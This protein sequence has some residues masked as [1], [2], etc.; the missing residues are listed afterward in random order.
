MQVGMVLLAS[1][2]SPPSHV[3]R[4]IYIYQKIGISLQQFQTI[5]PLIINE[6]VRQTGYIVDSKCL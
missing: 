1:G 3:N 5:L 6:E 2:A 4:L